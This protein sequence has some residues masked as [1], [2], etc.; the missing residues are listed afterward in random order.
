MK[1]FATIIVMLIVMNAILISSITID[2]KYSLSVVYDDSNQSLNFTV[3][4]LQKDESKFAI[5]FGYGSTNLDLIIT[6]Y[7]KSGTVINQIVDDYA[8]QDSIINKDSEIGGHNDAHNISMRP[9]PLDF[10]FTRKL[11][12]NDPETID[13]QIKPQ[14]DPYIFSISYSKKT[15]PVFDYSDFN[16][17]KQ[18]KFYFC[19]NKKVVL[20]EM[21]NYKYY[22]NTP[23]F[24][25]L[26]S[27]K[28]SGLIF[29]VSGLCFMLIIPIL[30][31]LILKASRI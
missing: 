18:F 14:D 15:G 25:E 8:V 29:M 28:Q 5:E 1:S 20:A 21:D 2:S 4:Y 30:F 26:E 19:L 27:T 31:S 23:I 17:R 7:Y 3:T 9:N 16:N 13:K 24:P 6:E 10:K 12:T 11:V 22:C